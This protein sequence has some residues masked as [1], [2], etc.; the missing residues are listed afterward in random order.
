VQNVR[1]A[2]GGLTGLQR[3]V[4]KIGEMRVG[5]S[6]RADV[7][8]AVGELEEV[9]SGSSLC[10]LLI[11]PPVGLTTLLY[12]LSSDGPHSARL[13]ARAL[14]QVGPGAQIVLSSVLQPNHAGSALLRQS[15][16]LLPPESPAPY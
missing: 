13:A 12:R 6:V 11:S 9:S 15:T 10:E 16:H 5:E 7:A 1:D 4:G 8:G 3:L 14:L 2:V